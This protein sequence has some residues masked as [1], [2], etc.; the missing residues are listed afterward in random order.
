MSAAPAGDPIALFYRDRV[1]EQWN[2]TLEEQR[3]LAEIDPAAR[4]ILEEMEAVR[5]SLVVFVGRVWN[6]G[7][8]EDP[9]AFAYDLERGRLESVATPS[10]APFATLAHAATDFAALR[11]ECGD[12]LLGFLGGLAGLGDAMRMTSL[13]V[14]SL[15]ELGAGVVFERTGEDG[16]GLV[17]HFGVADAPDVAPNDLPRPRAAIRLDA[18][19]YGRLQRGELDAQDA[20]LADEVTIE[21]DEG[22][23]IGLALTALSPE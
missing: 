3:A 15:R 14:R 11:R 1:P 10:R 4:R 9:M 20:F 13:R 22:L 18:E 12:S 19:T 7:E 21:G 8:L 17:A 6:A 16:F 5:A 2:E 23:A